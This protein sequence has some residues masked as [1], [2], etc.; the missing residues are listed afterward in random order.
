MK[1]SFKSRAVAFVA[2]IFVTF[3]VIELLA[4]YAFSAAPPVL[5]AS[6]AR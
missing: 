3:G 5:L 2:S 1:T 6:A 4:D